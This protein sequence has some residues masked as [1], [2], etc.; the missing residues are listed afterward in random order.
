VVDFFVFFVWLLVCGLASC[1]FLVRVLFGFVL[2]GIVFGS[3]VYVFWVGFFDFGVL[4]LVCNCG[5]VCFWF[6]VGVVCFFFCVFC[7]IFLVCFFVVVWC[8]GLFGVSGVG[9]WVFLGGFWGGDYFVVLGELFLGFSCY[10]VL[11]LFGLVFFCVFCYS[12]FFYWVG[13]FGCCGCVLPALILNCFWFGVREVW[14]CFV[15]VG[16]GLVGFVFFCW[17]GFFFLV[18][19]FF[20][21]WGLFFA[22]SSFLLVLFF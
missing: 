2:V 1:F 13:F 6:F 20:F 4:F 15:R 9:G 21:C 18:L 19:V 10:C 3:F 14:V 17:F 7:G 5:C 16:L 8:R 22:G 11:G 12:L